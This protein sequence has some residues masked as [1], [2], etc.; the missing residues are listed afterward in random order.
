[1]RFH[2]NRSR[3]RRG[4]MMS[5]VL[6]L[7][8]L[9]LV[10]MT[11]TVTLVKTASDIQVYTAHQS[12]DIFVFDSVLNV[13]QMESPAFIRAAASSKTSDIDYMSYV[14]S[15]WEGDI[16]KVLPADVR[17]YITGG[18]VTA[19]IDRYHFQN[20][21]IYEGIVFVFTISFAGESVSETYHLVFAGSDSP[22]SNIQTGEFLGYAL[23]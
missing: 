4:G 23:S 21:T 5:M 14:E 2:I 11:A 3:T 17:S 7:V 13:I 12:E 20:G 9:F 18:H 15:G 22:T 6:C 8:I 19:G 1:M 16:D 10:F